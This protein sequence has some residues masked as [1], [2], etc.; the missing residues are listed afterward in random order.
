VALIALVY[1]LGVGMARTLTAPA[2]SWRAVEVGGAL[3]LPVVLAVHWANEYADVETDRLTERTPFSGGSGAV[4]RTGVGRELL[5]RAAGV[6]MLLGIAGAVAARL[7]GLV[8]VT[9]LA[10]LLTIAVAG[11]A[12][13][14]PPAALVRRGVGELT[15]AVLGGV[16][17]PLYGVAVAGRVTAVALLAVVPFTLLVGCNLLA[18][19]WPDREA[20][21]AVGKRTLAVRWS[22]RGLRRAYW[23][24]VAVAVLLTIVLVGRVLPISVVAAQ[25]LALPPLLWGGVVLT[26]QRSPFP[27]VSAMVVHAGASTVAWWWLA[28]G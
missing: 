26:R 14:L 4:E 24:L 22:P 12:Y 5:A 23:L 3:L 9:A 13:S 19:H 1:A 17:L 10:L 27:A 2:I 11:L 28:F 15:N 7:T 21:A 16:L 20:D 8:S 18:T 6:A 25:V